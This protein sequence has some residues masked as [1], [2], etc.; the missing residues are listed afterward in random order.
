MSAAAPQQKRWTVDQYLDMERDS[1]EKHE[2]YH[3]EI[4]AMAG[5][6]P[7]HDAI[8]ANLIGELRAVLRGRC[9]VFTSDQRL[10]IPATGLFTY[11][12]GGLVC[13]SAEY[14]D[15]RPP[16]LLT[17]SLIVEVLSPGTEAYDRGKKFEF[18]QSIQSLQH[19][20]L[21]A[22]DRVRAEHF[23]RQPDGSWLLRTYCR[24]QSIP[25]PCDAT[26]AV[27][28]LYLGLF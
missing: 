16:S 1:L 19:F 18:Y 27:D 17:P 20:L 22:Q 3:G 9:R 11:S 6:S 10:H 8:V 14:T 25:L 21:L 13:G 12:D 5:A 7:E 15:H 23:S 4:F 2:F 24:G 28:E 26:L